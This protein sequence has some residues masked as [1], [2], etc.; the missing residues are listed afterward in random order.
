MTLISMLLALI[1]ERL[2]ARSDAWQSRRY[3][4]AYLRLSYSSFL[5]RLMLHKAGRYVWLVL[6]GALVAALLCL[7]DSWLVST[8]VNALILL[9]A[10][11]SWHYRQLYKQYLNALD[12]ED[13]EAATLTMEQIRRDSGSKLEQNSHGQ[14]LVWINFRYYAAV[15]FWFLVAGA[16][17][18]ITYALLRQLQ[19]PATFDGENM[20]EVAAA[21]A[22]QSE[23]KDAV[24]Y[25]SHWAD[26]F[27]ARLFGLGFALVGHFSRASSAL[28]GYFLDFTA[29]NEKVVTEVAAAAEPLP[30]GLLNTQDE[31]SY[32]VQ[33]AKRNILFFLAFAAILTLSGW[34]N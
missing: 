32:M 34:L 6:P 13:E 11:G 9:V 1:V 33:L 20:E 8:L 25:L 10:I 26:W 2:A 23:E 18:V 16:F 4:Q 30:E 24:H 27:P 19:E 3:S 22:P 17:G 7:A 12:R 5:S 29:S 21:M 28:L 14:L 15:V 31:T